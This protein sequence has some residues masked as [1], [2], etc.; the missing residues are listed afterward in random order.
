VAVL[1]IVQASI[2]LIMV[3]EGPDG[4]LINRVSDA[5]QLYT[6]HKLIGMIILALVLLRLANRV[7]RGTPPDEPT[8]NTLERE[9][10]TLVHAWLYFL[11]ITVPLLGWIGVSLYPALEVFGFNLPAITAPNRPASE[12]VTAAHRIAAFAL[13]GLI[14]L[15]VAGALFHYFVKR[16]GV[17]ARMWPSLGRRN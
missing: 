12:A 8:L 6:S 13:I 5:L 10:S 7:L 4:N 15:H 14:A 16:D 17:L 2:G 9:G 11:L 3:Y 1:V